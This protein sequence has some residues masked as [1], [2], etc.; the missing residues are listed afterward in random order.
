MF[1]IT[2]VPPFQREGA[3]V[4]FCLRYE[5]PGGTFWANNNGMNYVL[6]CHKR[7][8]R[9]GKDNQ[10]EDFKYKNKKSCLKAMGKDNSNERT[11]IA[12][13]E[14]ET[15]DIPIKIQEVVVPMETPV[16]HSRGLREDDRQKPLVDSN[17][18]YSWRSRRRTARLAR[19][20]NPFYQNEAEVEEGGGS[21]Q[22]EESRCAEVLL[23]VS[24]PPRWAT[25]SN[26]PGMPNRSQ[27]NGTEEAQKRDLIPSASLKS[28][29]DDELS[30]LPDNFEGWSRQNSDTRSINPPEADAASYHTEVRTSA[31]GSWK[32]WDTFVDFGDTRGPRLTMAPEEGVPKTAAFD[33]S[34]YLE[35]DT[36]EWSDERDGPLTA[37]SN[38]DSLLMSDSRA[39][40]R[41]R[42]QNNVTDLPDHGKDP[43]NW[44][45]IKEGSGSDWTPAERDS[46]HE[47]GSVAHHG[48][49][50]GTADVWQRSPFDSYLTPVA[51]L[52][53]IGLESAFGDPL[54]KETS[55][56]RHKEPVNSQDKDP[57]NRSQPPQE[58]GDTDTEVIVDE[59]VGHMAERVRHDQGI[60]GV[61]SFAEGAADLAPYTEGTDRQ[62]E[63]TDLAVTLQS[64]RPEAANGISPDEFDNSSASSAMYTGIGGS[65]H[66]PFRGCVTFT[67]TVTGEGGNVKDIDEEACRGRGVREDDESKENVEGPY[68]D[69]KEA[70]VENDNSCHDSE[71]DATVEETKD[72]SGKSKEE[73]LAERGDLCGDDTL[74]ENRE[75]LSEEE[76]MDY[77]EDLY[78]DEDISM[79]N[80]DD[81]YDEEN[82]DF[83]GQ[84]EL[85]MS[86][87]EELQ[88]LREE[89]STIKKDFGLEQEDT[90]VETEEDLEVAQIL[91]G[92]NKALKEDKGALP[93]EMEESEGKGKGTA[94]WEMEAYLHKKENE[95]HA[96]GGKRV[97]QHEGEGDACSEKEVSISGNVVHEEFK[98]RREVGEG[99]RWKKEGSVQDGGREGTLSTESLTDEGTN[100][101]SVEHAPL[102]GAAPGNS[103]NMPRNSNTSPSVSVLR[104]RPAFLLSTNEPTR[105]YGEAREEASSPQVDL[106]PVEEPGHRSTVHLPP[107][108]KVENVARNY[109]SFWRDSHNVSR[110][111][112]YALL[113]L[114][115][116]FTAFHYDF[117]TCFAFYLITV[118][119]VCFHGENG[120]EQAGGR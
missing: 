99:L 75:D 21:G 23:D 58:T 92:M 83:Y 69:E 84:E 119:W 97:R 93:M 12:L 115:F 117:L 104:I 80:E 57:L 40:T 77:D 7:S 24:A 56:P 22:E 118:Y 6:F 102:H 42:T 76:E 87:E 110:V 65:V 20:K 34:A 4:E 86:K 44:P 31:I 55:T 98:K 2:L 70:S 63:A 25:T 1:K 105:E 15:S 10:P 79:E 17:R 96:K 82:E 113:C 85:P 46:E 47:T 52:E 35:E 37:C 29:R 78:D 90:S 108:E 53:D 8:A 43:E 91:G 111:F 39:N 95:E 19:M 101:P 116:L 33:S 54:K 26:L 64:L 3:K 120:I 88:K 30:F 50:T 60:S 16:P 11:F 51:Q 36:S 109:L 18:N 100:M 13:P 67:Q 14:P 49:W 27:I 114:V 9:D 71:E 5:I 94:F 73:V 66:E 61:D 89:V 81:F 41:E 107:V 48:L 112:L 72:L 59:G 62:T 32:T 28:D 106:N 68:K 45:V 103:R 74:A 38:T